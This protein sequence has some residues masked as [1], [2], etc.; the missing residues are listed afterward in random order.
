MVEKIE[1]QDSNLAQAGNYEITI[2]D[3]RLYRLVYFIVGF[4]D[5]ILACRFILK[6]LGANPQSAFAATMYFLSAIFVFPFAGLFTP[7]VTSQSA[8]P[9]VIEFST[10]TAMIVYALLG[11]GI[12]TFIL[13]MRSKPT[14]EE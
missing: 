10:L 4:I 3:H 5:V 12:G 8:V 2:K 14:K 6:L 1:I 13:I 11:W 9:R 7:A